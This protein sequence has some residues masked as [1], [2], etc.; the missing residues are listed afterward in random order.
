MLAAPPGTP[1]VHFSVTPARPPGESPV[2]DEHT[3]EVLA[4]LRLDPETVAA[5]K[6]ETADRA[7]G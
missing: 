3:D 2:L 7:R 5:I 4:E 1:F 6:Q